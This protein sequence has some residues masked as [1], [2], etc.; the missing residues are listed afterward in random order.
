MHCDRHRTYLTLHTRTRMRIL[1]L[2][3]SVCTQRIFAFEGLSHAHERHMRSVV[4][5]IGVFRRKNR[6]NK[7][8]WLK[9]AINAFNEVYMNA[10]PTPV[11][12][13]PVGDQTAANA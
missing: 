5:A 12:V 8:Q 13:R 7:W 10:V 1:K 11:M 9:K 4:C 2:G 6:R 3:R